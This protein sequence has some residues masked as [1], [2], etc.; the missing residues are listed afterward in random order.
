MGCMFCIPNKDNIEYDS[1][2]NYNETETSLFLPLLQ[3]KD[4]PLYIEDD[5]SI[6]KGKVEFMSRSITPEDEQPLQSDLFYST[7]TGHTANTSNNNQLSLQKRVELLE[8]NTQE[9]L[10][11]LSEDI[12]HIYNKMIENNPETENNAE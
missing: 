10:Q 11:L 3:Q 1:N 5:V 2:Y 9:N 6:I 12:H 4:D 8:K 7:H